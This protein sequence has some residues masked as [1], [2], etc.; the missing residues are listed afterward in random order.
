MT[1]QAIFNILREKVAG[2]RVLELFCGGGSLGI[3]ALS[4]GAESAVFIEQAAPVLRFLVQNLAGVEGATVMR[5]D[6]LRVLP[7]LSDTSFDVILAD[8]PYRKGLIQAAVDRVAELG[9]LA[10]GGVFVAEHSREEDV[11]VPQ[12]WHVLKCGEYGETRVTVMTNGE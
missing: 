11:A 3:E 10:A 4:R 8:P 5:G 9:L 1:R 12:G 2:A 6:V 7:K